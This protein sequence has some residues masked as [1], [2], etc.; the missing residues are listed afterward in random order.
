MNLDEGDQLGWVRTSYGKDH[1]IIGTY[2]GMVLRF[3]EE[4]LRPLGRTA[5]GVRAINLREGDYVIG[6]D[7]FASDSKDQIL[8]VTTDGFGKRVEIEEFRVQNRAGV[9]LIGTKFKSD[10]SHLSALLVVKETDDV[11][12]TSAHGVVLRAQV[13]DISC[14]GRMATGVRLQKLDEE[15]YVASVTKNTEAESQVS[16][17]EEKK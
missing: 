15:D 3:N 16:E 12:I 14:Q 11:I 17:V 4:D 8:L 1:I 10:T 9:G 6:F 7:T 5:R 2:D 13:S